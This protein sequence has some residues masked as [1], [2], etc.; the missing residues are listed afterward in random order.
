[1]SNRSLRPSPALVISIIALVVALGG[2][3]YAAFKVGTKN[4]KNGAVTTKKLHNGA[5]TGKKLN[6]T[7][8]TAPN[9][10]HATNASELGGQSASA[11]ALASQP[12]F[13]DATLISGYTNYGNGFSTAGYMKDTL[14]FVHLTG[15]MNC[16][17]GERTAFT[18]PAGDRPPFNVSFP[19]EVGGGATGQGA[20]LTDGSVELGLS[21]ATTCSING[22]TFKAG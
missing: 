12:G 20:V 5:V 15:S 8:V 2:T 7:G 18:L 3:S 4:I 22:M 10:A 19:I 16:P 14:G 17:S 6:L 13:T 21:S 11:Y 1:M 9:A